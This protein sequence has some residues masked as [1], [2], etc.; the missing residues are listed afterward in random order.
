MCHNRTLS[1]GI[2]RLHEKCLRLFITKIPFFQVF[3]IKIVFI[4]R[5]REG[6]IGQYFDFI[7]ITNFWNHFSVTS[8]TSVIEMPKIFL[9]FRK[10]K[11]HH[12]FFMSGFLSNKNY[13]RNQIIQWNAAFIYLSRRKQHFQNQSITYFSFSMSSHHWESKE[14][15]SWYISVS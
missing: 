10:R 7:Y 5:K 6:K 12:A 15:N 8:D 13:K 1:N 11:H 9:T 4:S 2:D 14:E 3:L